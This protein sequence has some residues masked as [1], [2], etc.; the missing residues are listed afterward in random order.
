MNLVWE[1]SGADIWVSKPLK[2]NL[3]PGQTGRTFTV[4]FRVDGRDRTRE[5]F[6]GGPEGY[7]VDRGGILGWE[8]IDGGKGP[9]T[10]KAARDLAAKYLSEIVKQ[11]TL[12]PNNPNV[13][14]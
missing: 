6:R 2:V 13:N 8:A 1:K 3:N 5:S 7:R 9:A 11:G 14:N 10:P 12:T 4:V